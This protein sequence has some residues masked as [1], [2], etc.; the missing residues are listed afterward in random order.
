MTE[1][2]IMR[3]RSSLIAFGPNAS[4]I[5][6]ASV[7]SFSSRHPSSGAKMRAVRSRRS[8][9]RAQ[10]FR[11]GQ[12]PGGG[13]LGT[14]RNSQTIDRAAERCLHYVFCQ[15]EVVEAEEARQC[16]RGESRVVRI[17]SAGV[18]DARASDS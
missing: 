17:T 8:A 15:R 11:G 3:N 18:Y 10:V 14:P 5:V 9:S 7:H 4:S 1:E 6:G 12:Q 13:F 2:N 16:R